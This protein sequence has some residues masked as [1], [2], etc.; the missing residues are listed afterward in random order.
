MTAA[1]VT[2]L[3]VLGIVGWSAGWVAAGNELE[4]QGHIDPTTT[5]QATKSATSSPTPMRSSASPSPTKSP[6]PDTTPSR[7]DQFAMPNFVGQHF[8]SARGTARAMKLG[9]DVSFNEPSNRR[10]GFVARTT[11]VEGVFVWPGVTVHLH[12][13]GPPPKVL[14]PEIVGKPCGEAKDAILE[15]GLK[16]QAYPSGEKGNVT[17][18]EPGAGSTL[19]W[20]DPVKL[21][22]S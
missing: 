13:A 20:N 5:T 8:V 4:Q 22:C 17:K 16:I 6:T 21:F 7:A 10:D 9:V 12:V 11:P 1:F 3:L 14:V 15:A 19:N 18:V 2:T